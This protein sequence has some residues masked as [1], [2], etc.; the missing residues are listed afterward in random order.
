M[1]RPVFSWLKLAL[2]AGSLSLAACHLYRLERKLDPASADFLSRVSWIITR[3]ERKIF[4]ELPAAERPAFVEEFWRRR[5]P[6]PSTEE[7]EL[8]EVYEARVEEAG[9]LF[10]SESRPGWLT[11]RGRILILFGLP[12]ERRN[13][14]S[15]AS[16]S[17]SCYEQ[18]VYGNFP[19]LFIDKDC[20]GEY[21]LET[22]DLSSIR[23]LNLEYM[24][25]LGLAQDA[26][27]RELQPRDELFDI[28]VR[29]QV[30]ARGADRLA[31]FVQLRLP[32]DRLAFEVQGDRHRCRMELKLAFLDPSGN[33]V[34][35]LRSKP[36]L[37]FRSTDLEAGEANRFH[38]LRVPF[39]VTGEEAVSRLE[40]GK[41][42]LLLTLT[43][44]TDGRI[45]Q[46]R[47]G[48]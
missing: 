9:R 29:L 15:V 14:P 45:L 20:T 43:F 19:V 44:V 16:S 30:E 46:K 23:S 5:D 40:P 11:D 41:S 32:L 1:R 48:L 13:V 26:V 28:D 42:E 12:D 8:R 35:E 39:Q 6:N 7:N 33:P 17:L 3:Q 4:L 34:R 47:V 18:W 25:E 37:E 24:H 31:G 36:E 22:H 21:R 10:R 38:S 27:Q 2:L